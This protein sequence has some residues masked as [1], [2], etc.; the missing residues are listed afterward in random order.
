MQQTH[1]HDIYAFIHKG[2][3]KAMCDNLQRLGFCDPHDDQEFDEVAGSIQQ[4]LRVCLYRTG[5]VSRYPGLYPGW[6]ESAGTGWFPWH[7]ARTHAGG[8]V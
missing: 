3:R 6:H 2:L 1:R 5:A 8:R 7:G 4:L